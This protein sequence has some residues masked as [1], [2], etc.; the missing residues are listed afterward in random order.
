MPHHRSNVYCVPLPCC[1]SFAVTFS[2]NKTDLRNNKRFAVLCMWWTMRSCR[3]IRP[4]ETVG[5]NMDEDLSGNWIL[6]GLSRFFHFVFGGSL[7]SQKKK[8]PCVETTS[9]SN[10][11]AAIKPSVGLPEIIYMWVL[12]SKL[13]NRH[14]FTENRLSE[15][16]FT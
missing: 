15:S 10:L 5:C 1:R 4:V 7:W 3:R 13:Y 6:P 8:K 16:Y 12:G 2:W 11:V 9:V 14:E